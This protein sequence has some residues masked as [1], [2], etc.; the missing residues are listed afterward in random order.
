MI[1]F[2]Y[3]F[4][5]CTISVDCEDELRDLAIWL[6]QTQNRQR[7][8]G[9]ENTILKIVVLTRKNSLNN[10][11]CVL[12]IQ[13]VEISFCKLLTLFPQEKKT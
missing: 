2:I 1:D 4:V 11:I 5:R 7:K 3:H 13:C 10:Y 9:L 6:I 12:H 8:G